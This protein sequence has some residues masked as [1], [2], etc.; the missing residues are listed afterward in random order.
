MSAIWIDALTL[1]V[2]DADTGQTC[3]IT[4]CCVDYFLTETLTKVQ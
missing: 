3:G 4:E 1:N 2:D